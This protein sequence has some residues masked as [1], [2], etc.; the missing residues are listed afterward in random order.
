MMGA[1][2]L[3]H[4]L[5]WGKKNSVMF[6]SRIQKFVQLEVSA[7]NASSHFCPCTNEI[8]N[9]CKKTSTLFQHCRW[10]FESLFFFFTLTNWGPFQT[11][12][13]ARD[14]IN[15]IEAESNYQLVAINI[16]IIFHL[17]F[18]ELDFCLYAWKAVIFIYYYCFPCHI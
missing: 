5:F 4:T 11:M 8:L 2:L 13:S 15:H 18:A 3:S 10:N 1:T 16:I 12:L 9:I 17:R 14:V 7:S 6:M